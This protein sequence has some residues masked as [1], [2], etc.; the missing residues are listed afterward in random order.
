MSGSGQWI[1]GRRALLRE[2]AG[3]G[4][5]EGWVHPW[6]LIAGAELWIGGE[7]ARPVTSRVDWRTG[8]WERTVAGLGD[9]IA[10][11]VWSVPLDQPFVVW[12]LDD[13][14]GREFVLR[15]GCDPGLRCH[16]SDDRRTLEFAPESGL[17]TARVWIDRGE[18]AVEPGDGVARRSEYRGRGAG[19]LIA[20]AAE[21]GEL[22]SHRLDGFRERRVRH[23][24]QL[25]RFG[26]MLEIPD[27]ALARALEE[28]RLEA[29]ARQVWTPGAGRSLLGDPTATEG[30]PAVVVAEAVPAA[31]GLLAVGQREAARELVRFLART[32]RPDGQI[33]RR[34]TTNDTGEPGDATDTAIFL[35]LVA[36]YLAWTGDH[37]LVERERAAVD[38]ARASLGECSP[39]AEPRPELNRVPELL[40]DT[41]DDLWGVRPDAPAGFVFLAPRCPEAWRRMA[42]RRLRVGQTVLDLEL[43]R[44]PGRTVVRVARAAG[45]RVT[46]EL[47]LA[48]TTPSLVTVDE[49]ELGG[50]RVRF[51]G[52]GRH[53]VVFYDS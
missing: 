18:L 19:R 52:E 41:L 11:E 45:P 36:R 48:G 47:E 22:D 9:P 53:E 26:T 30:A 13:P 10:R 7:P 33:L 5:V 6:R 35:H 23:A 37:A 46:V 25:L 49:V 2:V 24:E 16:L 44:R 15:W 12:E 31:L 4:P 50:S 21:L 32:Q 3:A 34:Y 14:D 17:V 1:A 38:R 40:S 29:D 42:L 27:E 51:E 20:A 8:S 39:D 28:A 43:V